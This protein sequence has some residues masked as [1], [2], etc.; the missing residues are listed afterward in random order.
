[1]V[2]V[3]GVYDPIGKLIDLA[4]QVGWRYKVV[5]VPALDENDESNWDFCPGAKGSFSTEYYRRERVVVSKETWES[6][7]QQEPFETKGLVFNADEL[8]YY[9]A[10]PTDISPDGV[11]CTVDVAQG[12]GDY[13]CAVLGYLYGDNVYVDDVVYDNNMTDVTKPKLANFLLKYRPQRTRIEQNNG[14]RE[15]GIN[16]KEKMDKIEPGNRLFVEYKT[17]TANKQTKILVASENIKQHFYF[18]RDL[19]NKLGSEY[20]QYMKNLTSY[21]AMAKVKTDDAPDCT[22]MLENYI[23][24]FHRP[25]GRLYTMNRTLLGL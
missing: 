9:E 19:S 10:L 5:N 13:T 17:T 20:Y 15:F 2:H 11:F 4:Q 21:T 1:M 16:V 22:A 6:E 3:T 18:R 23:S 25:Q 8:N 24:E 12:G 7:F 14:G